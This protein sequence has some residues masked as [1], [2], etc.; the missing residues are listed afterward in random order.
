MSSDT[1]RKFN[2]DFKRNAVLLCAETGRSV[3]EVA[4]KIGVGKDFL[5]LWPGEYHIYPMAGKTPAHC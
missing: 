3:V 1:R 5:S 2:P 4:K